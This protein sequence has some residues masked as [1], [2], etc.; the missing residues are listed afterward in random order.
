MVRL[1]DTVQVLRE[2]SLI[3]EVMKSCVDTYLLKKLIV[4]S[5]YRAADT[6]AT[7]RHWIPKWVPAEHTPASGTTIS[8]WAN[9]GR[10]ML[11][12]LKSGEYL[13]EVGYQQ[14]T[15]ICVLDSR[16]IPVSTWLRP[17]D[18]FIGGQAAHL[19]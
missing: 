3:I 1:C 16:R 10:L 13:H 5:A 19:S 14:T 12:K 4:L 18:G 2:Q 6:S 9:G 8:K 7:T 15:L 17:S 11:D